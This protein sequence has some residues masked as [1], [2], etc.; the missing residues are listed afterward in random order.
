L[1]SLPSFTQG[2]YKDLVNKRISS[3]QGLIKTVLSRM[4]ENSNKNNHPWYD[5]HQKTVYW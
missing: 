5:E 4:K 2:K 1:S 3:H